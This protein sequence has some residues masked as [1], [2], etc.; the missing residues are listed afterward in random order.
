MQAAGTLRRSSVNSIAATFAIVLALAAGGAGG[1]LLKSQTPQL[2]TAPQG[3]QALAADNAASATRHA[4]QE[5][6]D[7]DLA[8]NSGAAFSLTRHAAQERAEAGSVVSTNP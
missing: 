8:A 6:A 7:A 1:Y 4:A 5:R 3:T 2:G